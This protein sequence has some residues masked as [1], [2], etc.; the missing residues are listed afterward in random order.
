MTKLHILGGLG[1]IMAAGTATAEGEI[2]LLTWEGYADDSFVAPFTEATGCT[3]SP[4]Y[5]GSGDEI[6][7]A[8]LAGRGDDYD[9]VSPS[10]DIVDRLIDAGKVEPVDMSRVP[11]AEG[12]FGA[13]KNPDYLMRGDDVY[14]VPYS[15]GII[16]I[17]A[18]GA[19]VTE[20]GASIDLLW[21]D[22]MEG[23]V[24]IWDDIE[25]VYMAGRYLGF[26]NVYEM[27]DEELAQARDAL[28]RMKPNVRKYWFTAGELDTLYQ[29]NEIVASNAWESTMIELI[30]AGR[31]VVEIIPQEG[32]GGW[33]DSWLVVE[34]AG[35]NDCV[36]EWLNYTASAEAHAAGF[37]VT[38][39]GYANANMSESLSEDDQALLSQLNM[40]N[41]NALDDVDWWQP[42]N[43]RGA[44]LEIWN[45]VK[46]ASN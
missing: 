27:S 39:F 32:R 13:F 38:G 28:L 17:I 14:G 36:Y 45:Q 23:Q 26:D 33:T 2:S 43:N 6:I 40:D 1:L 19:Q 24:A 18:D 15:Y 25:A 7:T 16:R 44:Y 46:A 5:I 41:P 9:L 4:K 22:G 21:S 3:V 11:N 34:G 30:R 12:F 35:A 8:L 10:S 42:V 20:P 37:S 29:Q 31:N